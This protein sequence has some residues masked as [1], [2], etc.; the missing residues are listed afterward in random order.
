MSEKILPTIL[1]II[2]VCASIPYGMQ[3]DWARFTYW[4]SAAVL[5]YCTIHMH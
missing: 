2:D 4:I 5:T 3:G 1:I